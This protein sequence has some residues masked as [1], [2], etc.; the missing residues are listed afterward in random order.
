MGIRSPSTCRSATKTGVTVIEAGA[1]I[2]LRPARRSWCP[3]RRAIGWREPP[4]PL[5]HHL[6]AV[7][8]DRVA[9]VHEQDIGLLDLREPDRWREAR[10][11]RELEDTDG[12]PAE[13]RHRGPG[14]FAGDEVPR[15]TRA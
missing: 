3:A 8:V 15:E 9:T 10:Q 14:L 12:P 6:G 13:L 1:V 4:V 7:E 2:V 11:R 5:R